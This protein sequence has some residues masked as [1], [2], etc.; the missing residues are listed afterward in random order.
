[1]F[2][3]IGAASPAVCVGFP[4]IVSFT[5][6]LVDSQDILEICR[7]PGARI[8][9]PVCRAVEPFRRIRPRRR[10]PGARGFAGRSRRWSPRCRRIPPR[11]AGRGPSRRPPVAVSTF[12]ERAGCGA[13]AMP[14]GRWD[15]LSA[16]PL[17]SRPR[18]PSTTLSG[19]P[20]PPA[21]FHCAGADKRNRSRDA[22]A[23]E[24]CCTTLQGSVA[25]P[26]QAKR[27]KAHANYLPRSINKSM[28]LPAYAC[29]RGCAP[30][31][32]AR[33][34]LPALR[35]RLSPGLPIPAQLQGP[36][37][38]DLESAGRALHAPSR[39]SPV[40]APHASAVVPKGMMPE[41]APARI[42]RPRWAVWV[43]QCSQRLTIGRVRHFVRHFVD[44]VHALP[45]SSL[46]MAVSA[47]L[48]VRAR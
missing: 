37:F 7:P 48:S 16:S 27:R 44:F 46:A 34:R 28:P 43:L 5:S 15:G 39:P 22:I 33:A 18:A 11:A 35:P 19:G 31:S 10:P 42:A 14:A 45:R 13:S 8:P 12:R 38:L 30:L 40:T 26:G 17:A 9:A 32:E 20:P 21:T 41:A 3:A 29:R 47:I 25:A 4:N 24:F 36:C 6:Y 1:M 2:E 23:S